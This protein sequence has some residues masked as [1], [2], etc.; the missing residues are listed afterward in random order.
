ML[1]NR[2]QGRAVWGVD[3]RP[4]AC[5]DCGLEP[6]RGHGYLSLLN[7]VLCQVKF[8]AM[9]RSPV[10]RSP[11][12]CGVSECDRES[13]TV[14]EGERRKTGVWLEWQILHLL[15]LGRCGWASQKICCSKGCQKILDRPS[16]KRRLVYQI[17][18]RALNT[19]HFGYTNQSVNVV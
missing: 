3:L 15:L 7:V 2:P 12:E 9:G 19:L 1:F 11:N 18:Y 8:S 5:W 14:S 17:Q 13:S 10:Q 16:A 4:L 6:H